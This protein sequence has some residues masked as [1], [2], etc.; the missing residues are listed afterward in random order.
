[1]R[2]GDASFEGALRDS[3]AITIRRGE[4]DSSESART[5]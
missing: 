3:I 5:P 1:M 2:E 4:S